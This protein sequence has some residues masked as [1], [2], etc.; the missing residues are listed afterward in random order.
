MVISSLTIPVSIFKCPGDGT[1]QQ[2]SV[3]K[4]CAEALLKRVIRGEL[5]KLAKSS[6]Q[7]IKSLFLKPPGPDR[8]YLI[9]KGVEVNGNYITLKINTSGVNRFVRQTLIGQD[10]SENENV[11]ILTLSTNIRNVARRYN[12]NGAVKTYVQDHINRLMVS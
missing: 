4:E 11:R 6:A 1:S 8:E 3:Y 10:N 5:K 9:V 12:R 7:Y 2:Q